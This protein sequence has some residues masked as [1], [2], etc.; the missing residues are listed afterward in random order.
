MDPEVVTEVM[1][2]VHVI[3]VALAGNSDYGHPVIL[4]RPLVS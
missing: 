3:V 4:T 2:T 1:L